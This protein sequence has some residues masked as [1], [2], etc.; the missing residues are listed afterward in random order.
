MGA[1]R[2]STINSLDP[3]CGGPCDRIR[4]GRARRSRWRAWPASA[5]SASR[6]SPRTNDRIQVTDTRQ[7]RRRAATRVK[8]GFDFNY[9]DSRDT[10]LPLH[11]GGRY[12]FRPLPAI[13]GLLPAPL[14]AIQAVALG[15]PAAY[16][17]G[18]GTPGGPYRELGPLAVR[19]GRVARRRASSLIKPGAALPAA[20]SGPTTSTRSPTWAAPR[21]TYGFPGDSNNFAP[22][23]AAGLRP[24]R[25]TAAPRC[26]RPTASSTTTRSSSI[27]QHHR[28]D[29]TAA[30]TAC[31]RSSPA[32]RASRARRL[33]RSRPPLAR[34][35]GAALLGGA[36]PSLVISPDPGLE[37][38]YAHQARGRDRPGLRPGLLAVRELRLRAR[39]EPGR[40]H[41]LQP[42]GPRRS[43][44]AAGPTTSNGVAGTS[45]SVLQ[46]TDFG[47]TWYKGLTVSLSKRMSRRHRVPALVHARQGRGQLHRLPER[48]HP[49]GQRAGPQPAGPDR[50]AARLRSRLSSA[51]RPPTTSGTAS[52]SRG[53][54]PA[55]LGLP[56]LHDRHRRLRPAVHA[57]RRAPTSTATA[58]AARSPAP[59]ARGANPRTSATSVGPQQR[60]PALDRS[61]STCG[62]ASAS[63]SDGRRGLDLIA[64]AFNLFD[65]VELL[66]D[67]QHLRH[68]APS[69]TSRSA[70]RR[71]G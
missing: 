22:R 17:Q 63:S 44:R 23:L 16:I 41:R 55:P 6:P 14:S 48:L 29:P 46:Y 47:E 18:Y 4:P 24:R 28:R 67:Q 65:R 50:A 19:P 52:C 32:S 11:F 36:Y 66:R 9:I 1:R 59:T 60:E 21:F 56:A 71:D 54:V 69:P 27:A 43:A 25:A 40:H 61:P 45:A 57:A 26:T 31:A 30:R 64:E 35:G 3:N 42:G 37:T 33:A 7:L 15:I 8:A 58:T 68:A 53:L 20:V 34:S 38:P 2:T 49:A 10:A 12:L 70:T 62:S 5:A 13:P 51:D 39:Q